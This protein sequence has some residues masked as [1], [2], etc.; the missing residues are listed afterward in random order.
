MRGRNYRSYICH[1]WSLAASTCPSVK[2]GMYTPLLHVVKIHRNTDPELAWDTRSCNWQFRTERSIFFTSQLSKRA[3]Y[4]L[5]CMLLRG[6]LQQSC[7]LQRQ[8]R[9]W[10][11]AARYILAAGGAQLAIQPTLLAGM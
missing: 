2:P 5:C 10:G 6:L 1:P 7:C 3:I 11:I 9:S 8:L 4:M